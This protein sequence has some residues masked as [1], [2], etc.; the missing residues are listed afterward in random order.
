MSNIWHCGLSCG[1]DW[2]YVFEINWFTPSL[3]WSITKLL[4]QVNWLDTLVARTEGHMIS[5]TRWGI[6]VLPYGQGSECWQAKSHD[7]VM[8]WKIYLH[9]WTFAWSVKTHWGRDKMAA[10][11]QTIF[12]NAFSSMKIYESR[13]RFHWN[14]FRRFE[15]TLCHHCFR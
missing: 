8:T 5:F 12:W 2:M 9:Y 10:I 4:S 7:D 3:V 6:L 11:F 15:L 1:D 14:V 13:L